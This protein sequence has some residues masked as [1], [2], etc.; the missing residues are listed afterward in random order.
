MGLFGFG[1]KKPKPTAKVEIRAF[2]EAGREIKS[3]KQEQPDKI[4]PMVYYEILKK[5]V[6]PLEDVL[7]GFSSSLPSIKGTDNR[8]EVLKSLISSYY[9]LKSKCVSLG[10]DYQEYFSKMWGHC[11]NSKNSDFSFVDK[12]QEELE[13][14]QA[15]RDELAA[16]DILYASAV[17]GLEEKVLAILKENP[18]ILQ[19]DIYKHFDPVVQNDIQSILYFWAKDGIVTR[20]KS[21]RTYQIEYI[22]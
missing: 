19:T 17:D 3:K 7:V 16:K 14:L 9:D 13:Y 10:P 1:K 6:K 4:Y 18:V 20:T 8:I 22:G 15:H 11:H 12:Y 21:G 5:E 2:D